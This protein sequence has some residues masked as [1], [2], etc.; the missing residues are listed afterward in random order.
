MRY[1]ITFSYHHRSDGLLRYYSTVTEDGARLDDVIALAF[2]NQSNRE[3]G[4]DNAAKRNHRFGLAV[5]CIV[6][7]GASAAAKVKSYTDCC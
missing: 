3:F 4:N 1:L 5:V 7:L 2:E 6:E